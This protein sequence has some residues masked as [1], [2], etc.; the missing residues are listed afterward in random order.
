MGD[1]DKRLDPIRQGYEELNIRLKQSYTGDWN[2]HVHDSFEQY[3][4]QIKT[5]SNDI[6]SILGEVVALSIE[7]YGEETLVQDAEDVIAEVENA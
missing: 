2:D 6:S 1:V 3:N 5:I 7:T 4:S